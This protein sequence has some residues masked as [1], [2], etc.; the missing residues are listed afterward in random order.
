MLLRNRQALVNGA[1]TLINSLQA[2]VNSPQM[3]VNSP[4]ALVNSPQALAKSPQMIVYRAKTDLD[5]SDIP[6]LSLHN[7]DQHCHMMIEI[8][9][10]FTNVRLR[11]LHSR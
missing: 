2:L 8:S 4:Q 11:L 7:A 10:R 1:Q 6:F 5:F 3:L 9:D